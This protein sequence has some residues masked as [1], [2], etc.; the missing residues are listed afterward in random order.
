M[1]A[2][3]ALIILLG[4]LSEVMLRKVHLPGLVGM[5]VT[6]V[7]AGPHVFNLIDPALM[8]V[9]SELRLMALVVILLRAGLTIKRDTLNRVGRPTLLM[10]VLPSTIEGI[11]IMFAAPYVFGLGMLES[12]LL[13]FVVAAVSPAVV[14]PSM[15][16]LGE[17]HLGTKK[18]IPTMVLAAGAL[19][20]ALVIVVFSSL[21][22][23]YQGGGAGVFTRLMDIPVSLALGIMSG[24][25]A[26]YALY[27]IFMRFNPRNTKKTLALLGVAVLLTWI[28]ARIKPYVPFSALVGV[29]SAGFILLEKHEQAAH[30]VAEKLGKIW[31]LAEILLFVLLGAQVD[32]S[33][34]MNAGMKGVAI[35]GIGLSARAFG[36]WLALLRSGLT[37]REKIFCVIAYIPKATVQA[38]IGA[39]PLAAGVAGG[40][41]ILA[42]AAMSVVITAPLGAVGIDATA[43]RLLERET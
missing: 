16:R 41:V 32:V 10:S 33:V 36:T 34:A 14:V 13:G 37:S 2:S 20:N 30:A 42:V 17:R 28:E 18:G 24:A 11:A 22:G 23:M 40:D 4:M 26:G 5:L 7:I 43:S 12:A 25:L 38:A 35:I 27:R 21:M 6:G 8:A 39:I 31:I 3:L 1:A 9:S 29:M 15:V 19:D